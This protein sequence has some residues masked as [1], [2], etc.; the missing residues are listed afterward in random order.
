MTRTGTKGL[1]A[2]TALIGLM[3]VVSNGCSGD[4]GNNNGDAMSDSGMD[5]L[6]HPPKRFD[7]AGTDDGGGGGD[8]ATDAP[9]T[10]GD[11]SITG[12][13]TTGKAC[14]K[15]SDCTS[16]NGPGV[17]VCTSSMYFQ[18]GPLN[19]T[20]VCVSPTCDLGNG[21]NVMFCDGPNP[22]DLNSPGICMP[23]GTAMTGLNGQCLPKCTIP[24]D[25][26]APTGCQGKD[27]CNLFATLTDTRGNITTIGFCLGG[28]T[29]NSDCPS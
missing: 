1:L 16:P 13:G 15:D 18:L 12:D 26:T 2:S 22:T 3:V 17:N 11:S 19:P 6:I 5:E 4:N 21:L 29:A 24:L 28:C 9:I 14:T 20:P 7:A 27:R 8:V 10:F 23:A 25:G